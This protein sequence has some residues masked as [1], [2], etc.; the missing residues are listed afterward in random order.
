M[1]L[2]IF[3]SSPFNYFVLLSIAT[4]SLLIR[5]S[6]PLKPNGKMKNTL[7]PFG[8]SALYHQLAFNL[9]AGRG[10]SGTYSSDIYQ[11]NNNITPK[12]FIP[13]ITRAPIYPIFLSTIYHLFSAARPAEMWSRVKIIQCLVDTFT[14]ILIYFIISLLLDRKHFWPLIGSFLYA[15]NPYSIFYTNTILSET[16]ATTLMALFI[17]FYLYAYKKNNHLY[18]FFSGTLLSLFVLCRQEYLPFLLFF[19]FL[20]FIFVDKKIKNAGILI[21]GIFLT[22][23]PWTIRN[24]LVFN[25]FIPIA[26]G[27]IGYSLFLGSF[28]G[29]TQWQGWGKF[30]SHVFD[31]K[32]QADEAKLAYK[33]LAVGLFDGSINAHYFDNYFMKLAI[34]RIKKNFPEIIITWA[35]NIPRLWFFRYQQMYLKKEAH[36]IFMLLYLSLFFLAIKGQ[37]RETFMLWSP[38]VYL[39][40]TFLPLH[41]EPRYCVPLIPLVIIGATLGIRKLFQLSM[42]T[43]EETI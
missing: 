30:P 39:T 17:T 38:C 8:D 13:A 10:Y 42:P 7:G 22:I 28:E 31:N 43:K 5:L 29:S 12:V 19:P 11:D 32:L 25:K 1:K 37:T 26:T 34:Q 4:L 16:I 6:D 36:W 18:Q 27:P 14:T 23:T 21:L 15:T 20:H 2:K 35:K 41:I 9:N 33:G 3:K 24:I 40:C